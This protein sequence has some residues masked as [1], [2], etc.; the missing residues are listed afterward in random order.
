MSAGVSTGHDPGT[1]HRRPAVGQY[2]GDR[3]RAWPYPRWSLGVAVAGAV[4]VPFLV[5]PY[6]LHQVT[7]VL[8][9]VVALLGLDLVAGHGGLISLGHGAFFGVGAYAAAILLSSGVP[10]PVT[11]PVAGL[12]AYGLG[13]AFGR[14]AVRL[15]GVYLAVVTFAVAVAVPPLIR[16]LAPG[17]A[18][19]LPVRTPAAPSFTG[20]ADDQWVYLL[21]LAVAAAAFTLMRSV[22]RSSWGRALVALRGDAGA[23]EL[24]GM[25]PAAIRAHAFACSALYAGLAGCLFTWTTGFVAAESFTVTLSITLLAG[26]VIGGL[27]TVSGAVIGAVVVTFLPAPGLV[28]GL[29]LILVLAVA[30]SGVT[31]LVRRAPAFLR[32]D[33]R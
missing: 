8:V 12:V 29:A 16:R 1:G 19:G 4:S 30:P 18:M 21:V 27:G 25:R 10:Y 33:R 20:L 31:G 11:L 6:P 23:A 2:A 24:L 26:I 9:Y 32:K 7:L 17:G 3:R 5:P 22:V 28:S 14:P 15:S 13:H